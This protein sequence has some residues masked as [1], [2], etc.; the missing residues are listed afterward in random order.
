LSLYSYGATILSVKA[1]DE[2]GEVEEVTLQRPDLDGLVSEKA[3]LGSTVGRI[4]N[5]VA[6]G[7]FKLNGK[8]RYVA[9]SPPGAMWGVGK[10]LVLTGTPYHDRRSTRWR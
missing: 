3:Y 8:V 9:S 2:K 6:N 10:L 1:P 4:A 7:R 5:R